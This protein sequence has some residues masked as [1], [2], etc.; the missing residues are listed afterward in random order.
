M[1]NLYF[2]FRNINLQK[3]AIIFF[4]IVFFIFIGTSL[5]AISSSKSYKLYTA[6]V[7]GGGMKGASDSYNAENSMG[8]PLGTK[9]AIGTNYKIYAGIL[10]TMNSIPTVN[11]TSF[12]DGEIVLDDTPAL[13]WSYEDKDTDPQR[14]YQVQVSKDNFKTFIVDSTLI[15]S[16][17]NSFT[18]PILPT[19]EQGISYRWRVRVNDGYDYSGWQVAQRGFR[20]STTALDAPVIWARVSP[21]GA[22]I[23][24]K[25]WQGCATPYLY[26]EYPVTGIDVAGYSYAWG[27]L[28]DDQID[29]KSTS[30]QAQGNLL[31]DGVRVFNLKAQNTAGNWTETANFEIWIDRGS[32]VVGNYSP[33]NGTIMAT[34][35][36]TI[37]ISVSDDKSGVNP[38]GITMKINH[39]S[40]QA[41]YD[42][43]I[44]SVIYVPSIPLSD[45][46]NVVSFEV[47]DI[48]GNKT[49]P[50]VWSFVVDTAAPTGS[51]IINNQDSLTNS[52]YV[53][54]TINAVDS[55]TGIKSMSVSNDGVFDT[56]PWESFS[57]KKDNWIL[58]AISGTRKVYVK[59]KDNAG[60]TSEIF[61]DTIELVII[62]PD[63]IITSGPN[64]ITASTEALFTFKATTSGCVFRWKFDNEEWSDW[65]IENSAKKEGLSEGN[66]YFKVQAAKDVNNNGEIDSDEIDPVPEERTWTINTKGAIKPESQKKKPFR[67]W[68][69]E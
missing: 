46:D 63:T 16:S 61:N 36:P 18:T 58:P 8:F 10:S 7:D 9:P 27:S 49:S 37:S 59:F 57:V 68:K 69:E 51:I 31:N 11:I 19:D 42:Q 48:V 30:Y 39:A 54:L 45:G 43:N 15:S 44:Q 21:A 6:A 50:L 40:V 52:V 2:N 17:D 12:N 20:L 56:E 29:T 14:Y 47:S 4:I 26:W 23:P 41:S 53:S 3:K 22:N 13:S 25:L 65:L 55:N 67:F 66:H 62:A 64:L 33:S 38:D 1:L 34:D 60:N 35:A 28:P 5:A 32:P 24:A